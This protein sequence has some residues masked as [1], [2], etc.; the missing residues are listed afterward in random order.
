[1]YDYGIRFKLVFALYSCNILSNFSI[2]GGSTQKRSIGF[3]TILCNDREHS[4]IDF[5]M[6]GGVAILF[7]ARQ[8]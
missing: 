8:L 2:C 3:W 7:V 5:S 4:S 1:M 6:L